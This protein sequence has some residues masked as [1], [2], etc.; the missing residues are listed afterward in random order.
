MK[1]FVFKFILAGFIIPI[2]F[3]FTYFIIDSLLHAPLELHFFILK[4]QIMLWPTSILLIA[5]SV[6][7]AIIAIITNSI[8]YGI[9]GVIVWFIYKRKTA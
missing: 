2:L 5:E 7:A 4:I 3:L 6:K 8:L 9:V 1:K